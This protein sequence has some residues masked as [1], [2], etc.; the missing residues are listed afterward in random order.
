MV[1]EGQR[2]APGTE[3]NIIISEEIFK[4]LPSPF[5]DCIDDVY[6]NDSIDSQFYRNTFLHIN[7]YR[8]KHCINRCIES[9]RPEANHNRTSLFEEINDYINDFFDSKIFKFCFDNCPIE[10]KMTNYRLTHNFGRLLNNNYTDLLHATLR[11]K[12]SRMRNKEIFN[13]NLL[14]INLYH[15]STTYPKISEVPEMD[16]SSLLSNLGGKLGLFMGVSV[17]SFIEILE[18][19]IEAIR[20]MYRKICRI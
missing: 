9:F 4:K 1:V 16:F 15:D 10:C 14:K 6:S 12:T 18:L 11:N 17:L 3:T 2:L 5:S 20:F 8:Q 19:F 13:K 7:S